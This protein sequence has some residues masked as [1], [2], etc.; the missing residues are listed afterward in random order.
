M[1]TESYEE[2][3]EA[4]TSVAEG[5]RLL[6]SE[7]IDKLITRYSELQRELART[8]SGFDERELDILEFVAKGL[9]NKEIAEELHWSEVSIKRKMQIISDKLEV[10]DRTSA[11]VSA[12][13]RGII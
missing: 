2:L 10:Q 7:F 5:R 11:A 8:G 4:I 9:T 12:I 1:K 3:M 13:R 6:S